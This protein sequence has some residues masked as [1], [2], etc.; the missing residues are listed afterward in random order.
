[1]TIIREKGTR[2]SLGT[3]GEEGNHAVAIGLSL[4]VFK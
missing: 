1:M 4:V 3:Y 2:R